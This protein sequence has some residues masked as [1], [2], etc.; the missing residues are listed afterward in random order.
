MTSISANINKRSLKPEIPLD[1]KRYPREVVLFVTV[2]METRLSRNAGITN[3][4]VTV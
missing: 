4:D 1:K 3:I 2:I